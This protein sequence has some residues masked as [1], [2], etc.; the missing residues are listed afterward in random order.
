MRMRL[1]LVFALS[2][3]LAGCGQIPLTSD[4]NDQ[5][6]ATDVPEADEALAGQSAGSREADVGNEAAGASTAYPAKDEADPAADS[7]AA[8]TAADASAASAPAPADM[9]SVQELDR[10]AEL[11]LGSGELK[12]MAAAAVDRDSLAD[13]AAGGDMEALSTLKDRPSYRLLY[14]QR[15]PAEKGAE[16]GRAAEVAVFRYDTNTLERSKVDLAS[17]KVE[18]LDAGPGQWA[19]LVPEEIAEAAAVARA[20]AKV[21]EALEAAGLDPADAK[22]NGIL[23][24]SREDGSVCAAKRCVRLFFASARL[25]LPTFNVVVNLSDLELVEVVDMPGF[26]ETTP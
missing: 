26:T 7:A 25:P 14:T 18:A 3:P 24:V 9:L 21:R 23:T 16:A 2:L 13:Q 19:P 8:G 5:E 6:Q 4:K 15:L 12:S 22:A 17:G 11:A 10:A 1:L 20:D